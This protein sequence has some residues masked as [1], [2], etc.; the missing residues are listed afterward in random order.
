TFTMRIETLP[1]CATYISG[2]TSARWSITK[3]TADSFR[4]TPKSSNGLP[5]FATAETE[6]RSHEGR[7][8][9]RVAAGDG[10]RRPDGQKA[11]GRT[12]RRCRQGAG[13]DRSSQGTEGRSAGK[14]ESGSEWDSKSPGRDEKDRG[15][16]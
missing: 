9:A 13:K 4:M 14:N 8:A 11:R 6:R 15:T 16:D 12:R 3:H 10:C 5:T 2:I 1:F 7:L